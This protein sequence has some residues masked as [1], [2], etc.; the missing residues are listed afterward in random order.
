[1]LFN[2][3][4][5]LIGHELATFGDRFFRG[6]RPEG[7]SG[8]W[9]LSCMC[10]WLEK[11]APRKCVFPSGL[12]GGLKCYLTSDPS[13]KRFFIATRRRT[14]VQCLWP[15]QPKLWFLI[16]VI[17]L[18]HQTHSI[19]FDDGHY[20]I[21]WT[22]LTTQNGCDVLRRAASSTTRQQETA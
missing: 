10:R 22:F 13:A 3:K 12:L 4:W 16:C 7:T 8:S 11:I 9:P 2:C 14:S 5:G 17:R 6:V 19:Y 18:A 15:Q 20:A 1:M 21:N